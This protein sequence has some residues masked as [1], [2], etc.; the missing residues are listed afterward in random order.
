MVVLMG[1]MRAL[2]LVAWMADGKA[3]SLDFDA[4]VMSVSRMVASRV[5]WTG[6]V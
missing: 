1:K 6:A 5:E 4:A 3:V 2:Q